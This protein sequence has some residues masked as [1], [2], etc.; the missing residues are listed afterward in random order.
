MKLFKFLAVFML[1]IV[2]TLAVA[3]P[4]DNREQIVQQLDVDVGGD[5]GLIII[6]I[7]KATKETKFFYSSP[8]TKFNY[9]PL[10]F[11]VKIVDNYV[12]S[13]H[14]VLWIKEGT[15]YRQ[16]TF[17]TGLVNYSPPHCHSILA[18][19]NYVEN[20]LCHVN[21]PGAWISYYRCV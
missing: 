17:S 18:G 3:I 2:S 15:P 19:K 14:T 6:D 20:T 5:D 4:T 16:L 10:V 7:A 8:V 21:I 1:A 13:G 9:Q 12:K 11:D